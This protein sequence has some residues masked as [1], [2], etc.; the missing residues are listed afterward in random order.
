MRLGFATIVWALLP[1]LTLGLLA[2]VPFA[3]AAVRLRQRRLW[4][5]TAA[6]AIGSALLIVWASRPEGGQ[7]DALFATVGLLLMVAATTHAFLLRRRVFAP[8]PRGTTTK[9]RWGLLVV[10]IGVLLLGVGVV[11]A[12]VHD[13][14][15]N[16]R[17][18][19]AVSR[20]AD[21]VVI[22]VE[23]VTSGSG[24]ERR[25]S[26]HPVV[27]FETSREQVIVF[28]SNVDSSYRVGDAVK[29]RY[30]PNHPQ[31]ARL[32]SLGDR[33]GGAI[34]AVVQLLVALGA[35]VWGGVIF[36]RASAGA[37]AEMD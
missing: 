16:L 35:T 33:I 19:S 6:Y 9:P 25:T 31:R 37:R 30:E 21:G 1:L 14:V 22:R 32:D 26:R 3:V 11:V 29:V 8:S 7:G 34:G 27:R 23:S 24:S 4:L 13:L 12:A 15:D 36:A 10:S 2:P 5:V 17:P 20:R 28:T 18:P